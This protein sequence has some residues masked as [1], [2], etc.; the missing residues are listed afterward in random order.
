MEGQSGADQVCPNLQEFQ[1]HL[2]ADTD[3]DMILIVVDSNVMKEE[4]AVII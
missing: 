3:K 2:A 1:G 4:W